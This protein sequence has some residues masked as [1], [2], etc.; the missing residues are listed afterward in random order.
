MKKELKDMTLEELWQLF[1][2]FLTEHNDEWENWYMEEAG[3]LK[4]ILPFAQ[5]NHI[6]STSIKDIWAKP[7]VDILIQIPKDHDMCSVKEKLLD[8]GLRL[9]YEEGNRMSFNKGYTVDGFAERVFHYHLRYD[10]DN[11]EIYFAKY[12]NSHE[13]ARREYE[14]LKL[15]L[16]KKYE[17][18]RDAYTDA[19][20][21]VIRKYTELGKKE[22]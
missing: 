21:D 12:L 19:K 22:K 6:G 20:T 18:N 4:A 5:I 10:G 3:A 1:P 11:D 2:I 8:Y 17:H 14:K 15:E 16:W 13:E 9:M 7:I